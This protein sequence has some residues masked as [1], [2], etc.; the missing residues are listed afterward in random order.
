MYIECEKMKYHLLYLLV[1]PIF[2]LIQIL[3]TSSLLNNKY[4][5]NYFLQLFRFY[6]G[7]TLSGILLLVIKSRMKEK[8]K[9][10]SNK[11]TSIND[12]DSNN[13]TSWINPLNILQKDLINKNR[14]KHI[15]YII[16]L[17]SV[18][19]AYNIF[20]IISKTIFNEINY[21]YSLIFGKQCIGVFFE[22][23]YFIL[24]SILLLKIKI[25]KHH[26]ISLII[27]CINLILIVISCIN[28]FG[29]ITIYATIHFLFYCLLLSF[30]YVFGKKYLNLFSNSAYDIMFYVGS[31]CAGIFFLYDII[32]FLIDGNNDSSF[33]GIIKG[34]INNFSL[35]FI[36]IFLLDIIL[37]FASNVGIWL[38]I[39]YYSP[40]HLIISISFAEYLYFTFDCFFNPHSN[41]QRNDIILYSIS[42]T[43]NLFFFL[44]FNEIIILNFCGLS[45]NIK[46]NI[47]KRE[48]IDNIITY[49]VTEQSLEN[50]YISNSDVDDKDKDKDNDKMFGQI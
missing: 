37:F 7:H 20:E 14:I 8:H 2:N 29:L 34:F 31:I 15:R 9:R 3:T 50:S 47:Q 12:D 17:V 30:F 40:F 6:L 36:L 46:T 32:A 18:C 10:N 11:S 33:H 27:I 5:D 38:T 21:A 49:E 24:F 26:F 4:K 25:Y 19:L 45:Y 1:F 16:I 43:I 22:I 28:Y 13:P 41:Y 48:E 44:V 35:S 23:F 42:Y 39:Y